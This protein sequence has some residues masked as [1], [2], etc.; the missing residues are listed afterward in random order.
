LCVVLAAAGAASADMPVV[1][2]ARPQLASSCARGR[3]CSGRSSPSTS[4]IAMGGGSGWHA[5]GRVAGIAVASEVVQIVNTCV[6]LLLL[7]KLTGEDNVAGLVEVFASF[8]SGMGWASYPAYASLLLSITILPVMS[9]I[10]FIILAGTLFGAVRGTVVVSLSLSTAAAVSAA[11][12]RH[13]AATRNF[14]LADVD[15][16]A[17]AV[18]ASIA[19]KPMQTSLLLVTLLRLSPV[20]PFTFSNYLAGLTSLPIKVIF[21]GTLLGTLPT[22]AVYVSAGALGRQAL[23]GGVQLPSWVIALGVLATGA[24]IVLIGHVA[25]QTLQGMDLDPASSK[26]GGKKGGKKGSA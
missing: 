26:K 21:L 23:Q 13:I 1:A 16:S 3:R 12:S 25:Q 6:G 8:F 20:L 15:P 4:L 10:L 9:A 19:Q 11:L 14:G 18:D 24:A 7:R 5:A 17:A 22:Q 2:A